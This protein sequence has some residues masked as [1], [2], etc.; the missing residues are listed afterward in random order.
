MKHYI[1]TSIGD[2]SIFY[3]HRD[4]TLHGI[5]QGNGAG[6]AIWVAVSSPLLDPMRDAGCGIQLKTLHGTE[7]EHIVGFAFVD[8]CDLLQGLSDD[9][10]ED[11]PLIQNCLDTWVL[12]LRCTGGTLVGEKSNWFKMRFKWENDKW[13]MIAKSTTVTPSK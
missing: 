7:P 3:Q 1:R 5:L 13:K 8:D 2:S 10:E 6:P 4:Q 9:E 12:D 11:I